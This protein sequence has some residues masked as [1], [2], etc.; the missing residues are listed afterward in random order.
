MGAA[1]A[2]LVTFLVLNERNAQDRLR[3]ENEAVARMSALASGPPGPPQ[4]AGGYRFQWVQGGDL[5]A[6]L[7][8]SPDGTPACLFATTPGG[9]VYS[10]DL[11][12]AAAPDVTPLRVHVARS[13]ENPPL[14]A[15]WR[16][17]R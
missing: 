6:L 9:T 14:P 5:P 11:F 10:Y 15:G 7:L 16:R 17:I 1:A 3:T 13:A 8:A 2:V 4:S 12:D